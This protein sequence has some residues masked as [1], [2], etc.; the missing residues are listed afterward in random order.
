[1]F[2]PTKSMT[3]RPSFDVSSTSLNPV[4]PSGTVSVSVRSSLHT[5]SASRGTKGSTLARSMSKGNDSVTTSGAPRGGWIEKPGCTS[6]PFALMRTV[7]PGSRLGEGEAVVEGAAV[8]GA[9]SEALGD[10][11]DP[12]ATSVVAP[13]ATRITARSAPCLIPLIVR[14]DG[15]DHIRVVLR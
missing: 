7:E 12:D 9:A 2:T 14:A 5:G 13:H 15:G 1:M 4:E 3:D 10:E 11:F 6:A 8:D